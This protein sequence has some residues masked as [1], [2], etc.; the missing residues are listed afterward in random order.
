MCNLIAYNNLHFITIYYM[1]T[2]DCICF[3]IVLVQS[4]HHD[5]LFNRTYNLNL[6]DLC[7]IVVYPEPSECFGKKPGMKE[8]GQDEHDIVVCCYYA[9]KHGNLY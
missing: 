1:M 4:C 3:P 8:I 2:G 5:C 7:G 6:E 9:C